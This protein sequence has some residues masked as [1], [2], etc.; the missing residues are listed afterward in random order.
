MSR[1]DCLL[2]KVN[3]TSSSSST[4]QATSAAFAAL[5]MM[6]LRIIFDLIEETLI[7]TNVNY[8][9]SL[10]CGVYANNMEACNIL[11][12]DYFDPSFT[13]SLLFGVAAALLVFLNPIIAL[14]FSSAA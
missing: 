4:V 12:H 6:D 11:K 9:N 1:T 3:K 10:T 14:L 2:S 13:S 5:G 8:P 7:F